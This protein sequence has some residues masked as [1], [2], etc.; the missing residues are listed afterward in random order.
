MC[1]WEALN[2]SIDS[3]LL[4]PSLLSSSS[5]FPFLP[6]LKQHPVAKISTPTANPL[7]F[8][9]QVFNSSCLINRNSSFIRMHEH[10]GATTHPHACMNSCTLWVWKLCLT[11]LF[12]YLGKICS[13]SSQDS[14]PFWGQKRGAVLRTLQQFSLWKLNEGGSR[15]F[16]PLL[17]RAGS[18]IHFDSRF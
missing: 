1:K 18:N 9:M 2:V 13:R 17:H 15:G 11:C 14:E 12:L 16:Y 10:A 3:F 4:F 6:A 7:G 8:A 5:S